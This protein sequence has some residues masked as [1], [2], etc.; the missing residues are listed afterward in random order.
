MRGEGAQG[1]D[2]L[3][4]HGVRRQAI[5]QG[6]QEGQAAEVDTGDRFIHLQSPDFKFRLVFL[7]SKAAFD[8]LFLGC[9]WMDLDFFP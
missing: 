8:S 7:T 3:R 5:F 2:G 1:Q 4:H 6:R 9:L